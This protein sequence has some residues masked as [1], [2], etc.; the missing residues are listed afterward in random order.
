MWNSRA[1]AG[2]ARVSYGGQVVEQAT[3]RSHLE[4]VGGLGLSPYPLMFYVRDV[5]QAVAVGVTGRALEN[6]TPEY[7][8]LNIV[9]GVVLLGAVLVTTVRHH[10]FQPPA[11]LFLTTFWGVFLFFTLIAPGAM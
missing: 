9:L 4:R 5:V 11:L 10:R 3:Y 8:S 6:D 2:T 7:S 1:S